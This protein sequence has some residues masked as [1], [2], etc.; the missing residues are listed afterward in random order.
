MNGYNPLQWDCIKSGCFN[1]VKRPKI[2]VFHD[3]FYGK[4][5]MS[6]ID[7]A[8]EVNGNFLI[9][10]WKSGGGKLKRA[11]EIFFERLT[12]HPNI[13]VFVVTGDASTMEI[14]GYTIISGGVHH[15]TF[16]KCDLEGFR[17]LLKDFNDWAVRNPYIVEAET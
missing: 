16:I 14:E 8:V 10:E 15:N 11:Q 12:V 9:I 5:S 13:G 17:K 6:D 7:A 1:S 4:I 2:E 3:C